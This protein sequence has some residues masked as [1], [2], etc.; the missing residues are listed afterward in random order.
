MCV[1]GVLHGS[2][3]RGVEGVRHV[4]DDQ[5][6]RARPAAAQAA[7]EVVAGEAQPPDGGVHAS[8][9]VGADAPLAVHDPRHGLDADTCGAGD[10]SH[11]WPGHFY[12]RLASALT[13]MSGLVGGTLVI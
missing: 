1:R 6:E 13:T 8:G 5:P 10:V 2:R 11:G 3:D 12:S 9:R 4:L 7:G